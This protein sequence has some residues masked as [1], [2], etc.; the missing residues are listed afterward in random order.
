MVKVHNYIILNIFLGVSKFY[1][2]LFFGLPPGC[3]LQTGL[4]NLNEF[5][6]YVGG[7]TPNEVYKIR[8]TRFN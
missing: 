3:F 5:F 6:N 2:A 7:L 1:N 8:A 4:L